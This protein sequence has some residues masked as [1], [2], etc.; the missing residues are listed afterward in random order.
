MTSAAGPQRCGIKDLNRKYDLLDLAKGDVMFA[1]TGVTSGTM[2]QGVRRFAG[3]A[4][5]HSMVMRSKTGTVRIIEAQHNFEPQEPAGRAALIHARRRTRTLPWRRMLAIRA[6]L[7]AARGR[8]SRRA[9]AGAALRPAGDHRPPA[10]VARRRGRSRPSASSRRRCAISCP[11]RRAF[12]DMD[13]AVARIVHA[14]TPWRGDRRLRRLRRRWRDLGGAHSALP[15][16]RRRPRPH[17]YPR[18]PARRLWPQRAGA[19]ALEGGGRRASSSPS[20][21]APP[22]SRR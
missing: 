1:A 22:P 8:R 16:R 15:R 10:G 14:V 9:G 4:M 6:A 2:L 21:A 17:L 11:T 5:T 12:S 13:K 19:A 3:G 20:I 18:S 7:A